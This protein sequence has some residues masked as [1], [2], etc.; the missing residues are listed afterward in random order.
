MLNFIFGSIRIK[1]LAITGFGTLLVVAT[2]CFG[3]YQG[4][5]AILAY[6]ELMQN[7]VQVHA[8]IGALQLAFSEQSQ[9]WT[10][11][12]LR[13][14]IDADR[15]RHWQRVVELQEQIER[16]TEALMARVD[17]PEE[18]GRAHV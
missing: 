7:E 17:Q 11:L 14:E 13:G 12:L 5:R 18:I 9:Q 10:S 16:D 8:E 3:L 4:W 2:A 6:E 1:L 15:D